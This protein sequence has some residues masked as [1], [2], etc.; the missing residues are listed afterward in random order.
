MKPTAKG[1]MITP[2]IFDK[3][4]VPPSAVEV[5]GPRPWSEPADP[6]FHRDQLAGRSCPCNLDLA[7]PPGGALLPIVRCASRR[8]RTGSRASTDARAYRA[9]GLPALGP[10]GRLSL[11]GG[12]VLQPCGRFHAAP[13]FQRTWCATRII[14]FCS[15]NFPAIFTARPRWARSR[16]YTSRCSR[17]R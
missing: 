2:N 6:V 9:L 5:R 4:R 7:G 17:R 11:P 8:F 10:A 15:E 1:L 3:S 13:E 14:G 12:A 16:A